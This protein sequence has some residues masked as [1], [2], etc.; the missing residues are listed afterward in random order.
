MRRM[1]FYKIKY[2][3]NKSHTHTIFDIPFNSSLLFTLSQ[4]PNEFHATISYRNKHLCD[5]NLSCS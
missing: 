2:Y 5:D 1:I 4:E 3:L